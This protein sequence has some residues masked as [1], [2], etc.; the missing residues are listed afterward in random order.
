[1]RFIGDTHAKFGEYQYICDNVPESIQ[2]GDFGA[3]FR[4]IP[5]M[6]PSHRFIRGNH[7]NPEIC[8]NHPN[9]IPDITVEKNMFFLGGG[10][11]IDKA[12]R[13]QGVDWWEDEEL[14]TEEMYRAFDV[15][16]ETKPSIVVTHE[17]P[18]SIAHTLFYEPRIKWLNPSKTSQLLESMWDVWKPELWIFGHW[19][20]SRDRII[21]DTRFI[22]LGELAYVDI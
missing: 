1:M 8:R 21:D 2:V 19:H 17:C 22:C 12:S 4:S 7:D 6:G 13:T 14:S 10:F 9:W 11:S 18:Y 5:D 16:K 3:G 15:Y 20:Q